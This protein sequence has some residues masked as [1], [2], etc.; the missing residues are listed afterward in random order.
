MNQWQRAML[1]RDVATI[2]KAVADLEALLPAALGWQWVAPDR[3]RADP[4]ERGRP[5]GAYSD[6]T[7]AVALDDD[8]LAL[9]GALRNMAAELDISQQALTEAVDLLRA[10]LA[11]YGA[12]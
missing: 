6:P 8:R 3:P 10:A 11:K 9:R 5:A 12:A 4:D 7:P 2:R 1:A